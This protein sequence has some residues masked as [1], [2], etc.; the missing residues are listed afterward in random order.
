MTGKTYKMTK[1]HESI[2][3]IQSEKELS[4]ET[5]KYINRM[6]E[7][8]SKMSE[9]ELKKLNDANDK[10]MRQSKCHHKWKYLCDTPQNETRKC[11]HCGKIG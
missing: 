3:H 2:I 6:A 11:I 1:L 9:E 10:A 8:A 4:E 7:F 5:I